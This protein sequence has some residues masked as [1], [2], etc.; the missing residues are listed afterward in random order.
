MPARGYKFEKIK[1]ISTSGLEY[2]VC[3]INILITAF[4]TIFRRFPTTVN[5]LIN[6]RGVY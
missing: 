5:D 2:S 1:F 3:Y 4:L 6:A